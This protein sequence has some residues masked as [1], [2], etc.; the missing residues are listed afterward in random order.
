MTW[1]IEFFPNEVDAIG[2]AINNQGWDAN[3]DGTAWKSREGSFRQG[4][5]RGEV[6]MRG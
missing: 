5:K 1:S 2:M 3:G 6:S 4:T